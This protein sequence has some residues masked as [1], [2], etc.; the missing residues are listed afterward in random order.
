MCRQHMSKTCAVLTCACLSYFS[1]AFFPLCFVGY[2]NNWFW[3]GWCCDTHINTHTKP[4]RNLVLQGN[5]NNTK[6]S[7]C[8][9]LVV[10]VCKVPSCFWRTY[11]PPR[12]WACLCEVN[13]NNGDGLSHTYI[14][15]EARQSRLQNWITPWCSHSS[16]PTLGKSVSSCQC[17]CKT[18]WSGFGDQPFGLAAWLWF[19]SHPHQHLIWWTLFPSASVFPSLDHGHRCDEPHSVSSV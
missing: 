1:A 18:E 4:R 3:K 14:D 10:T 11:Y 15:C 2:L 12:R 17:L 7:A 19:E 16:V 5:V 9:C 6:G 13:T 8:R